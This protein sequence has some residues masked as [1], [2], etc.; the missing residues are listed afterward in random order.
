MMLGA[1]DRRPKCARSAA[2]KG[3]A[4]ERG[5]RAEESFGPFGGADKMGPHPSCGRYPTLPFLGFG[6]ATRGG[7]VRKAG[8][9]GLGSGLRGLVAVCGNAGGR[10]IS[11]DADF[12]M[13]LTLDGCLDEPGELLGSRGG[14]RFMRNDLLDDDRSNDDWDKDSELP[15][16]AALLR[17]RWPTV[18]G[19][20]AGL[21][22]THAPTLLDGPRRAQP[23]WQLRNGLTW[24]QF[25][26]RRY[27]ARSS[28]P[29]I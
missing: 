17:S 14:T 13:K 26:A 29:D 24:P 25:D 11:T 4:T 19:S 9:V 27:C 3:L 20:S 5:R 6:L 22:R 1:K 23:L 21:A 12:L 16:E 15:V 8:V 2:Q 28:R 18:L 7:Q 10:W